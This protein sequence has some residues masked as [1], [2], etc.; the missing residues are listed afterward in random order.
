MGVWD[1]VEERFR[2]RPVSWKRQYISKGGVLTLIRSTLSS[3]PVYFLSMFR[4]PPLV[5]SRREKIK[6]DFLWDGGNLEQKPHLVNWK[7]VCSEKKRGGLGVRSLSKLN[8]ALL[9]KWS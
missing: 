8:Q 6:R 5:C 9:C 1:S 7:I 3:L 2:K 4:M